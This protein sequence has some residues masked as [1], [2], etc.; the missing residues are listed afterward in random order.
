MGVTLKM[1]PAEACDWL[2]PETSLRLI[3]MAKQHNMRYEDILATI[4][5]AIDVVCTIAERLDD[6]E[7]QQVI[8]SASGIDFPHYLCKDKTHVQMEKETISK[9][10]SIINEFYI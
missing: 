8:C 2:R 1:S 5:Q 3:S 10:R 7:L 6:E 9:L 4:D